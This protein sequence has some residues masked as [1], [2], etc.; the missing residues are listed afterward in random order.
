[1]FLCLLWWQEASQHEQLL[2]VLMISCEEYDQLKQLHAAVTASS[3][4]QGFI[5]ADKEILLLSSI[6]YRLDCITFLDATQLWGSWGAQ[7]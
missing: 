3:V 2:L 4:Q 7:G 6:I 1:M 5:G